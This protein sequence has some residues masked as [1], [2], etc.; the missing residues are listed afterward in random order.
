VYAT[1]VKKAGRDRLFRYYRIEG[2][3]HVDSLYDAFPDRLRPLTPCHH[4]AF[5]ALE[6]WL[7]GERPPASATITRPATVSPVDCSL[8]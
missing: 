8:R 2:G 4:T 7:T 5:V 3:T 6:R 1:L